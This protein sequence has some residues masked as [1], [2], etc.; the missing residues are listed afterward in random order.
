[1]PL[2]SLLRAFV[3]RV[4]LEPTRDCSQRLLRPQRL[5]ISPPEQ[6]GMIFPWSG[7][8]FSQDIGG[9][10]RARERTR[11]AMHVGRHPLKLVR[12]PISPPGRDQFQYFKS[13]FILFVAGKEIGRASC[14]ERVFKY[15]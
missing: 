14:W 11:T 1:M 13:P 8:E 9:A 10:I 4:G 6:A 7:I 12:L 15:L 5:P 3:L 2:T